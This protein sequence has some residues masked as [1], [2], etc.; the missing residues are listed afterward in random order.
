M[1]KEQKL[2]YKLF[3]KRYS[4]LNYEEK[5]IYMREKK[6][7]SRENPELVKKD[8][9]YFKNWWHNRRNKNEEK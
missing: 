7:L 9:E 2:S 6:R 5:K 1:E 8:R 3:N 4:D